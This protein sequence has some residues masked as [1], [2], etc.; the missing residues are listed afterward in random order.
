M[1]G[2]RGLKKEEIASLRTLTDIVFRKGMMDEYPQLFNEENYENLRVCVDDGKVVSHVGMKEQDAMLFGCRIQTVCIGGVSTHPDYRKQGLASACFDDARR[3]SLEDGVDLMIVSGDRNLY[4]MRACCH[5]GGDLSV[6]IAADAIP[7]SIEALAA[8]VTVEV[9]QEGE[10]P[11]IMECYRAEPARFQ[12]FPSDY[13]YVLQSGWAMNRPSHFLAI[14]QN[15]AFRG[16]ALV[17]GPEPKSKA[18][19]AEFAGDR[20]ALLAALPHILRRYDLAALTFQVMRHDGLL[21]SLCEQ[22]GLQGTPRPTPGTV[23]LINFPQL[24]ERMRPGFAEILGTKTAGRLRFRQDGDQYGIALGEE[25]FVTDAATAVRTLFGTV[26]GLPLAQQEGNGAL[27]EALLQILPL[28]TLWYGIN[29][30]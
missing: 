19:L 26:E 24:L 21:R 28:P 15:G 14:R 25:E 10:L 18:T 12:R 2:P 5:V 23:T 20:H 22:N 13:H 27:R 1:E 6:T 9:M 3:K 8:G 29:Y 7:A 4:R 11:R 30:V 17:H 16:Y